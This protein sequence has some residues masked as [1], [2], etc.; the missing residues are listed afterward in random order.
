MPHRPATLQ[1]LTLNTGHISHLERDDFLP[2]EI[3]RFVPVIGMQGGAI[4][5]LSGW[6]VNI[7][8]PLDSAGQRKDGA[9]FLHIAEQSASEA[10][11]V[12]GIVCWREDVSADAWH[13][14]MQ[15][16]RRLQRPLRGV[17]LWRTVTSKRPATPWISVWFTPGVGL[18]DQER[19]A[20]LARA[21]QAL[22]WALIR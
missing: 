21:E 7:S 3:D 9:A 10:P 6:F 22:A 1:H 12:M 8:F 17:G 14:M 20:S 5:G 11:V 18:M 19:V 13:H 2:D 16:Y 4:P 15:A